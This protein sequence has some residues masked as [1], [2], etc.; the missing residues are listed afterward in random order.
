MDLVGRTLAV[1]LLVMLLIRLSGKRTLAE[2]SAFDAVLLLIISEATQ[3]ALL[4]EDF[5]ITAAVIMIAMLI[6]S[7]RALDWLE[8]RFDLVARLS[9]SV[10]L[11]L[12]VDGRPIHA[13]LRKSQVRVDDLMAAERTQGLI[14][15][16]QIRYAVL[17]QSGGISIIPRTR[18]SRQ[19]SR[20]RQVGRSNRRC[21]RRGSGCRRT[22]PEMSARRVAS[23]AAR[24]KE[25]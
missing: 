2:V 10:P 13:H 7:D 15:M 12:V 24:T 5:S 9:Q 25:V 22:R 20:S 8:W 14:R 19:V 4:G 16:D 3:Q 6:G 17:E 18:R 11:L 23:P 1:Y 21:L